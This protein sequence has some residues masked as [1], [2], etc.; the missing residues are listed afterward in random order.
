MDLIFLILAIIQ[1]MVI[2]VNPSLTHP[3]TFPSPLL[4]HLLIRLI[5]LLIT[6][7]LIT[8]LTLIQI[9]IQLN[10]TILI[11]TNWLH[12]QFLLLIFFK[13]ISNLSLRIALF[14]FI[15]LS[16]TYIFMHLL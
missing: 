13:A 8:L 4:H 14:L 2:L 11:Q 1:V 6:N 9:P 5:T 15:N 10:P 16:L 12:L 3:K 7:L